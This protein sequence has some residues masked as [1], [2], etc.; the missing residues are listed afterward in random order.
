MFQ[1]KSYFKRRNMS[2]KSSSSMLFHIDILKWYQFS[3][4]ALKSQICFKQKSTRDPKVLCCNRIISKRNSSRVDMHREANNCMWPLTRKHC[5]RLAARKPFS[6]RWNEMRKAART[7]PA[8]LDTRLYSC[9]KKSP[10][11]RA[12]TIRSKKFSAFRLA[13]KLKYVF[14]CNKL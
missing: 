9:K 7:A 10:G 5:R 2:V 3:I 4:Q 11:V 14:E 1:I 6:S 12:G 8:T 13:T